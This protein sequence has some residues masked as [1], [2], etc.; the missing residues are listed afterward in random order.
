MAQGMQGQ[1]RVRRKNVNGVSDHE[2]LRALHLNSRHG[3]RETLA[4]IAI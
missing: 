2:A 1:D 3:K 4:A